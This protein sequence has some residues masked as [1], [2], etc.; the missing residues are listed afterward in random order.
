MLANPP[1]AVA[2]ILRDAMPE[3]TPVEW[4][5]RFAMNTEGLL[6]MLSGMSTIEQM[7]QNIA[8]WKA[9]SP[10]SADELATLAAARDA[11]AELIPVPCTRCYYCMDGCPVGMNIPGVM[12]SINVASAYGFDEG[13]GEYEWN[14]RDVKASEC[15]ACGQCEGACPQHIKIIERL[16]EAAEMFE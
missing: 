7:R 12:A 4:A 8:T 2:K 14:A 10:L 5:L 3:R 16:A 15:V 9:L 6:T 11:L 1:E 13:K